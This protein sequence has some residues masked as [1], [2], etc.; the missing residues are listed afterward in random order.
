MAK[1]SFEK[2]CGFMNRNN[3]VFNS[4]SN[5]LFAKS[6]GNKSAAKFFASQKGGLMKGLNSFKKKNGIK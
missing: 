1:S 6:S 4:D 5:R 2:T 3:A